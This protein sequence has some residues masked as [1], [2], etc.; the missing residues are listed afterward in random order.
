[1]RPRACAKGARTAVSMFSADRRHRASPPQARIADDL[2]IGDGDDARIRH[3]AGTL[4]IIRMPALERHWLV[5]FLVTRHVG[6]DLGVDLVD[7]RTR[8]GRSAR[9]TSSI[10]G[11]GSTRRVCGSHVEHDLVFATDLPEPAALGEPERRRVPVHDPAIERVEVTP[12][13]MLGHCLVQPVSDAAA[14]VLGQDA[15]HGVE[16]ARNRRRPADAAAES[17]VAARS[18]DPGALLVARITCAISS[19]S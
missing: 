9:L 4:E 13:G 18:E 8:S 5:A 2:T 7:A 6:P 1:M 16:A 14:A 11:G 10:S 12:A 3:R 17:L 15:H 19:T